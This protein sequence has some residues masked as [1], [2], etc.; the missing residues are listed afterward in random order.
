ML[1]L[2]NTIN[3]LDCFGMFGSLGLLGGP[4]VVWILTP[5]ITIQLLLEKGA[6]YYSR[7]TTHAFL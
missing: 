4:Y 3:V 2:F 1:G 7:A 5:L 6:C